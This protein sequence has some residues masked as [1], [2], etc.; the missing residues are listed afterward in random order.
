MEKVL[1]TGASG[2]IGRHVVRELLRRGYYVI[3]SDIRPD[4]AN[5]E[6]VFTD[7]DIFSGDAGVYDAFGRPDLL[8]HMA[9]EKGF[10]HGAPEHMERLSAH[11][12]FLKDMAEGGLKDIAVMGSMHEVG[13]FEGAV[14]A[15][16]PCRPLSLY[17]VSKNALRQALFI[18]AGRLGFSLYWLRGFY[19]YGDDS[20]GS[21]IFAKLTQAAAE[22]RKEFP[23][24][25]G[26]NKYDF[27]SIEELA[28]QIVSAAT[29]GLRG[30]EAPVT[31]IINV[32]S[33][34]AISLAEQVEAYIS[35]NGFDIT[36]EYGA[37]PD[38]PYDSKYIWGD[39]ELIRGILA[40][41]SG[42]SE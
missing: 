42:K 36:L 32:C 30:Q 11:F 39:D 25:T 6:A 1:V 31:G 33:G 24:T 37:F 21:S 28:M 7:L 29:Q 16:T 19:I 2:Y 3:A 12:T 13:F 5:P 15:D 35:E 41:D 27:I 23:F 26:Q 9:W 10:V 22:G 18:E 14:T 34:K 17:G 4:E 20:R 40:G 8:I 38:R